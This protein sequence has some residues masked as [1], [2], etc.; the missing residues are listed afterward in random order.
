LQTTKKLFNE[1][2]FNKVGTSHVRYTAKVESYQ[3]VK[4]HELSKYAETI[5]QNRASH[6]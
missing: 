2:E 3:P 5:G 1:Q 4:S 6:I